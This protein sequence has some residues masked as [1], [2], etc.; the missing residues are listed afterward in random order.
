MTANNYTV[1]D[2]D[3]AIKTMLIAERIRDEQGL[4]DVG[5]EVEMFALRQARAIAAIPV[6]DREFVQ[7][8]AK[9]IKTIC[10]P[11]ANNP[12]TLIWETALKLAQATLE[13]HDG[14]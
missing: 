5:F 13:P 3:E 6:Q 7:E 4:T 14:K 10:H 12:V 9:V 8:H 11:D 2:F 1:E